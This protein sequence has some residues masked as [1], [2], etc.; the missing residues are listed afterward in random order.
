MRLLTGFLLGLALI[1]LITVGVSTFV[2][3]ITDLN[4][5]IKVDNGFNATFDKFENASIIANELANQTRTSSVEDSDGWDILSNDLV[6]GS[7][8][9]L[10]GY[11]VWTSMMTGISTTLGIPPW[12]EAALLITVSILLISAFFYLIFKVET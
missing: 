12:I 11:S 3:D 4:P 1:G 9:V 10:G 8:Q 2:T 6:S 5:D 7:K